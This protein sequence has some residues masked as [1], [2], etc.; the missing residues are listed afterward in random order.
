MCFGK[1]FENGREL[2]R[3]I[4]D[5]KCADVDVFLRAIHDNSV[6]NGLFLIIIGGGPCDE[7]PT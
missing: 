5:E 2:S 6:I 4:V 3:E 1:D 7:G